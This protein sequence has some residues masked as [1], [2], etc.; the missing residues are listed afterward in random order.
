MTIDVDLPPVSN[1][2]QHMEQVVEAKELPYSRQIV[3]YQMESDPY[4]GKFLEFVHIFLD[5]GSHWL[6]HESV[7]K[8]KKLSVEKD[9]LGQMIITPIGKD[10]YLAVIDGSKEILFTKP[11]EKSVFQS[12]YPW[13]DDYR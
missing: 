1:K 4:T 11:Q 7:F 9:K 10:Q 8:D 13:Q 12:V 6:I 3:S 5:D 2:P